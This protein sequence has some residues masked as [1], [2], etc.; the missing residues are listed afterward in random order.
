MNGGNESVSKARTV[1]IYVDFSF[2][3][4][5]FVEACRD[6]NVVISPYFKE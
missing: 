6:I 5:H 1:A 3:Q 4:S 2:K